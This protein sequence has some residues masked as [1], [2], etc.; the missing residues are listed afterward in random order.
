M[1]ITMTTNPDRTLT[2][3]CNGQAMMV[4]PQRYKSGAEIKKE[5]LKWAKPLG[6]D[7]PDGF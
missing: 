1:K 3:T 5:V 4:D 6:G 7:E 2:F